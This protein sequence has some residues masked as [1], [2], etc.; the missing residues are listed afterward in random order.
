M[1]CNVAFYKQDI[2][3]I[4]SSFPISG[5]IRDLLEEKEV[6]N[7]ITPLFWLHGESHDV[8]LDIMEHM[9]SVGVNGFI[10]E[11]RPFPD[12]LK[13]AW[14]ETVEFILKEAEKRNLRVFVFDDLKFP[15]GFAAGRI[16]DCHPEY[17]K[18][19]L[20]ENHLDVV[21]PMKGASFQL[22]PWLNAEEQL[23][24][25]LIVRVSEDG[26]HFDAATATDI[27]TS[28]NNE[29]VLYYDIPS[30]RHRVFLFIHTRDGGEKHTKN[31]INPL[32]PK[33]VNAYL[34]E[35]YEPHFVHFSK[36]FGKTFAGFFSDEPRFGN[37]DNYSATLG[38]APMVLPFS[39]SLFE[40][41]NEAWGEKFSKM[42]PCLWYEAGPKTAQARLTYMDVVSRLYSENYTNQIGDWCR[43]HQVKYIG[44]LVE[45]NGAHAR[46]GY[47]TGHYFRAINGQDWSGVDAVLDQILPGYTSGE[48]P[49]FYGPVDSEFAYWGLIKLATSAGH[50]DPRKHGTTF[51]E[52]FG[53]YGWQ[54]GLKLMK[55]LTDHFCVRGVNRFVPHAFSAKDFPDPDCP[56]HFYAHGNNPQWR[57]FKIWSDYANRLCH[58]LSGGYHVAPVA[59]VYHAEAEWTG[60]KYDPFEKVVKILMQR[61]IDCDI[62]PIDCLLDNDKATI[63]SEKLHINKESYQVIIVPYAECLQQKFLE[64]MEDF[65]SQGVRVVFM[66]NLPVC[67]ETNCNDIL[68]CLR[69]NPLVT[70][71]EYDKLVEQLF[72]WNI[73]DI[74]VTTIEND[75][76]YYHYSRPEEDIY[77]FVNGSTF[78][79]IDTQLRFRQTNLPIEYNPMDNSLHEPFFCQSAT[80]TTIEM[81]LEPYESIV[82]IFFNTLDKFSKCLPKR[83]LKKNMK[84]KMELLGPWRIGI[85][86]AKKFPNFKTFHK[87]AGLGNVSIQECLPLFSGTIRY[88][89]EFEWKTMP[90]CNRVFLDLGEAYEI[91]DISLNG[92]RAG[93]CIA[94]PYRIDISNYLRIGLNNLQIDITNTLVKQLGNTIFDCSVVHEPSGLI[95][96]VQILEQ[97]SIESME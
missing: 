46:L 26:K 13:S 90:C 34:E 58:L 65:A 64:K 38:K 6:T 30:G 69:N 23:E 10:L 59:I 70:V 71:C 5:H 87:I 72:D 84:L 78:E 43:V 16:G 79:T 89:T 2:I 14:W 28:V 57:Y 1:D 62:A 56:P 52:A 76:Q 67:C 45:D 51:C 31:Y 29:N 36:Y 39:S 19:Y 21:G 66:Q 11:S 18:L 24:R 86:T 88:E 63:L 20:R 7:Y 77:F 54:E 60:G 22:S 55:W 32:E 93:I 3:N 92:Q 85:A 74:K 91:V 48:F 82:I 80:E 95:G 94:P 33:A 97:Q 50:L 9:H 41:L 73:F 8:L 17:L 96:P 49:T 53:A 81:C 42:L 4:I 12:F 44:H 15:S 47:G 83:P 61:Q 35:V 37:A 40:Y 68:D 75:L 25:V 27:T